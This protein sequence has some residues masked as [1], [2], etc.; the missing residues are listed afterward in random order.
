[1]ECVLFSFVSIQHILN[2]GLLF[3]VHSPF[4]GSISVAKNLY[5]CPKLYRF[6]ESQL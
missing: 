2:V 4:H 1:M 5:L 3:K 6:F